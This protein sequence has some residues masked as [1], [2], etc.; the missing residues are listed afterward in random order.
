[1]GIGEIVEKT[2][3]DFCARIVI[4]RHQ[5]FAIMVLAN[6]AKTAVLKSGQNQHCVNDAVYYQVTAKGKGR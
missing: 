5:H 1:M 4:A 3:L 2:T 6:D